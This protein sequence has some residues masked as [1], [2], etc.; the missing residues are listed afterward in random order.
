M[1]ISCLVVEDQLPAQRV[2]VRYIEELP[3][4][5]L[6]G[7]CG[8]AFEAM[9][10]LH[11]GPVDLMFLDLNLPRL[12]GFEFLR[13]LAQPP[14]VIVTTAYPEHAVEGFDLAVVDYLVKPI[15]FDRFIRAVDRVRAALP[16]PTVV[17]PAP[18]LE[19]GAEEIFVKAGNELRRLALAD[20]L[21]I[22]AERDYSSIVTMTGHL[23]VSGTLAR[24]EERLPSDRFLR[25]H[26]SYIVNLAHVTS[27]RG[28]N[29]I[30]SAGGIP[31]GRLYREQVLKRVG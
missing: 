16:E 30:T 21:F 6:A 18:S 27:I 9:A 11:D 13:S 29:M 5:E 25:T 4:L 3:H 26:K 23:F 8:N 15:A 24:W 22:R 1:T 17:G 10:A 20:I 7:T 12:G 28:A 19:S 2:L 14:K 31:I